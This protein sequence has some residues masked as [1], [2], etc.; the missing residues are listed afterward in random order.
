MISSLRKKLLV[1]A[2]ALALTTGAVTASAT[3]A[4][5]ADQQACDIYAAGSTPCV[6]AHSTTRALF[7]AYSGPLYQIQRSSDQKYLDIGLL[8]AGGYVDSAPQ[9]SFCA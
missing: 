6:T 1:A 8:A 2:A 9:V 7:G 5:A 4:Q 3:T